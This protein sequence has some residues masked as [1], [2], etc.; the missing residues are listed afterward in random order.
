MD[1]EASRLQNPGDASVGHGVGKKTGG[2]LRFPALHRSELQ[3]L[4]VNLTY[5]CNQAC[6]H[7][8][9]NAGP[10]RTEQMDQTTVTLIP[11]VLQTRNFKVLDLTGGA[12]EMHPLFRPLVRTAREIGVEVIDRCNLTILLEEDH[13]DLPTFL[14]EHGVTI[15]A[16]L[17]CYEEKNVDRQRGKGVFR[18]SLEGLKR[19]NTVGYGHKDSGLELHLTYNPLGPT[20]PPS[21]ESLEEAY[22]SALARDHGI[23]FNKLRVLTNMPIQR[24]A[25][26]LQRKDSLRS[27]MELLRANHKDTNLPNVMCRTL[28]SVDWQGRIYDCDFNQMLEIPSPLGLHL[29]DLLSAPVEDVAINVGDHCYGCTAGYGSSCGGALRPSHES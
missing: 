28:V 8:H 17:P 24:F 27:Y 21:E 15:V 20:L 19:L 12:P 29:K 16:S 23:V 4:Q 2:S 9:V 26:E 13:S 1:C 7:C 10:W 14:A 6:S 18:K 11:E 25:E 3:I 22:K 5:R